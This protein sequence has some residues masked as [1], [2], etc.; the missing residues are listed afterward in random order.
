MDFA[1]F[2]FGHALVTDAHSI[3]SLTTWMLIVYYFVTGDHFLGFFWYILASNSVK[4]IFWKDFIDGRL[5]L[6]YQ[7]FRQSF[8]ILSTFRSMER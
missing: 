8:I 1:H 5:L 3:C 7:V 6:N 4:V 2:R